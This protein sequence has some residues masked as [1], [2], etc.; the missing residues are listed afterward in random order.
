MAF[1]AARRRTA[2]DHPDRDRC[3]AGVVRFAPGGGRAAKRRRTGPAHPAHSLHPGHVAQH[4][5]ALAARPGNPRP[6][7]DQSR[8]D[9][10]QGDRHRHLDRPAAA[11]GSA[12]HGGDE[13]DENAGVAGLR[14][15]QICDGRYRAM[16]AGFHGQL[17][18][19][20]GRQP[21]E[22]DVH[23]RRNRWRQRPS[24]LAHASVRPPALPAARAVRHRP[25][26]TARR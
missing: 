1:P 8:C 21:G 13:G 24:K 10:R 18:A 5:E 15:P 25:A 11:R 7:A 20:T 22:A 3:R 9:G 26:S 19:P 12:D 17:V 2:P 4:G 6:R 16:A 23:S 14:Q